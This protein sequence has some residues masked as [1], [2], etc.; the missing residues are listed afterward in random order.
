MANMCREL[1]GGVR[2]ERSRGQPVTMGKWL[3]IGLIASGLALAVLDVHSSGCLPERS[4]LYG[5][6]DSRRFG[7][8]YHLWKW[9]LV[10]VIAGVLGVV[11]LEVAGKPRKGEP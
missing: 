4:W 5:T 1:G 8:A 10:S 9:G 7:S 11:L 2:I 3:C 6:F